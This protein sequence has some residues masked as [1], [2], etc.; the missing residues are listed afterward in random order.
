[1]PAGEDAEVLIVDDQRDL[2]KIYSDW[3]SDTYATKTAY[4]GGEA[5]EKLDRSTDVVLLDRRMPSTS[6]RE[7]LEEIRNRDLSCRIAM[8]TAMKPDF[9]IVEMGFD[10][11][12]VKPVTREDLHETVD[13][14]L[15]R[16]SYDEE[17]REYFALVSKKGILE[18]MKTASEL[19]NSE[20][21]DRLHQ[22][23]DETAE[24]IDQ[25]LTELD[26]GDLQAVLRD[27]TPETQ[28]SQNTE[29]VK[30]H[31]YETESSE[32]IHVLLIG[33]SDGISPQQIEAEDERLSVIAES[34]GKRAINH[35]EEANFECV[36]SHY[37][38]DE[39]TGIELLEKVKQV[40]PD[41]PFI[42]LPEEGNASMARRAIAKGATDYIRREGADA[43]PSILANEI[44]KA[45]HNYRNRVRVQ[46]LNRVRNVLKEAHRKLFKSKSREEIERQVCEIV[47]DV[48][49]FTYAWIGNLVDDAVS[50]RIRASGGNPRDGTQIE[51][52]R[53]EAL[54]NHPA[55]TAIRTNESYVV[56]NIPEES[57]SPVVDG[58]EYQ[59]SAAIPVNHKNRDYGVLMIYA[60][61]TG[62]FDGS[63]L[64]FLEELAEDV[65]QSL[66]R[67][68]VIDRKDRLQRIIGNLPIGVYRSTFDD[69]GNLIKVN[70]AFVDIL[71]GDSKQ[72]M[73][74]Y[75]VRETYE[76]PSEREALLQELESNQV[77]R[78]RQLKLKTLEGDTVWVLVTAMLTTEADE[79]YID[80][81]MQDISGRIEREKEL[82]YQN[83]RLEEF[84]S[85]V[86]HDMR[87]PLNIIQGSIELAIRTDDPETH[88]EK[89]RRAVS[90]MEQLIDDVLTLTRKEWH[91]DTIKEVSLADVARDSWEIVE[92]SNASLEVRTDK[93][94]RADRGCLRQLF[95]NLFGNAVEQGSETVVVGEIDDGFYVEDD[96][97]GIPEDKREKVFERGFTTR[98]TGTGLGLCIVEQVIDAHGWDVSIKDGELGGAKFL[99]T[100]DVIPAA[101]ECGD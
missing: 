41:M 43:L 76:D 57:Q 56:R 69:P 11:Y 37:A 6:G 12:L 42:L 86:S 49:D 25:Q 50:L 65:A 7:V 85:I 40:W 39:M 101:S 66:Y 46:D 34:D 100:V 90:R 71:G 31:T 60:D 30:F 17:L 13:R 81:I 3:L 9:D 15:T 58:A 91:V 87:N 97:P 92:T 33:D 51:C 59:S 19:Q 35:L 61:E 88:L 94:I 74:G 45:V 64:L 28:N 23:I 4:R 82:E 32:P 70:D 29:S 26:E 95:E 68:E 16:S 72:E 67:T 20:T 1:M 2:A 38:L 63:N 5:L 48:D 99:V 93:D 14:L 98:E 78:N 52:I 73:V 18:A 53:E 36:V 8:L 89:S 62:A 10:D 47:C 44:V 54:E 83:K 27:L 55:R 24:R 77:V 96:G 75:S 80:G 79:K 84:A 21:Y 22:K